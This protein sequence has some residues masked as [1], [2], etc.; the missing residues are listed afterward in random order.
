M[1]IFLITK[2]KNMNFYLSICKFYSTFAAE[3]VSKH[4]KIYKKYESILQDKRGA[5]SQENGLP[6]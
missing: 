3:N 1:Q 5:T 2:S 4:I 6:G